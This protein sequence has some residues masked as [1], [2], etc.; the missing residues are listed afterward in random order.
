MLVCRKLFL[1]HQRLFSFLDCVNRDVI[2]IEFV[3]I[4]VGKWQQDL[5]EYCRIK[6]MEGN[7]G[8]TFFLIFLN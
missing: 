1:R 5:V 2:V 7:S 8:V 3:R 4:D 6:P